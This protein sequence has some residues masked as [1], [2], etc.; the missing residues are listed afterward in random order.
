MLSVYPKAKEAY[1]AR[2]DLAAIYSAAGDHTKAVEQYQW[3]LDSR[4]EPLKAEDYRYTIALEYFKM[5]DL[6]QAGTELKELLATAE[7][8]DI[9]AKALLLQGDTFYITGK[10]N[11]AIQTFKK[12]ISKLPEDPAAVKAAFN[13]AKALEDT[14]K[15]DEALAILNSLRDTYPNKDVLER[16]IKGIKTRKKEKKAK[17]SRR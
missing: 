8:K 17:R 4:I 3:I 16:T 11:E 13:L 15:E 14:D 12:I 9:I 6:A 2:K 5:N 10:T 7:K 1:M